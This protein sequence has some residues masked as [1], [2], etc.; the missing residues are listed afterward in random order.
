MTKNFGGKWKEP[1]SDET[2]H[3]VNFSSMGMF[4]TKKDPENKGYVADYSFL[5][6]FEYKKN[7]DVFGTKTFYDSEGWVTKIEDAD[8][9]VYFPGDEHWGWAK[10]KARS[11]AFMV[12][13]LEHVTSY[14]YLWG[15]VPG[16]A[17]RMYLPPSHPIRM[18]LTVHFYRTHA[19]C[20]SAKSSL[21][22]EVGILGRILPFT[23]EKG[24]KAS[25]EKLVDDFVYESYPEEL[26]RKGMGDC[27]FHAG[28]TDGVALHKVLADY[29]SNLFDEVYRTEERLQSDDGM[30]EVYNYIKDR[31]N[32]GIP[33]QTNT[34]VP[35]EFT[36]A[37]V[38]SLWGEILFRVTGAHNASKYQALERFFASKSFRN[39]T[40]DI[41]ISVTF[42]FH[43]WKCSSIRQEPIAGELSFDRRTKGESSWQL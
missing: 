11:D 40:L 14:H 36:L 17:L 25:Y 1:L 13:S 4:Y 31:F 27:E 5:R 18:A 42:V 41:R 32:Q 12:G 23:Y 26:E 16:T 33:D 21:L 20:M 8:G 30:R 19:T 6:E 34:G 24:L 35:E 29:I 3:R 9:T 22:D 28:S 2:M 43:S 7:F 38:K 15:C 39:L 37:N 10:L